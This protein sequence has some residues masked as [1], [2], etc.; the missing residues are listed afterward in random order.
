MAGTPPALS[1]HILLSE[2]ANDSLNAKAKYKQEECACPG[3]LYV[4]GNTRAALRSDARALHQSGERSGAALVAPHQSTTREL[5]ESAQSHD[6]ALP[7]RD[8]RSGS[9]LMPSLVVASRASL[10]TP[11]IA[12]GQNTTLYELLVQIHSKQNNIECAVGA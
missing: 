4:T 1:R 5:P 10:R 9:T 3:G 11:C 2:Q 7:E 12:C 6:T 8:H